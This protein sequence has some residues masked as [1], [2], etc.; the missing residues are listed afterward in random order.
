[1]S[2]IVEKTCSGPCRLTKLVSDFYVDQINKDQ[3]IRYRNKC[4][5][6]ISKDKA[7]HYRKHKEEICKRSSDYRKANPD[8]AVSWRKNNPNYNS[9]YNANNI[10]VTQAYKKTNKAK[11]KVQRAE[12]YKR[13]RKTIIERSIKYSLDNPGKTR[14]TKAKRHAA[15]LQRTVAWAN[16]EAI[17]DI[18]KD[19]E[20]I[21]LA[22]KTAGC[23]EIFTV[24]HIIPLQGKLVSGLHVEYNLDIITL[25]NNC[26]KSNS[27]IPS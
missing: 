16:L 26:S 18:Y 1:M 15:K 21:N 25:S 14:A 20:E 19:C 17:K 5:S 3:S 8:Y 23:T 9:K 22:A 2:N 13:N 4:K 11:I 7:K 6:C 24:D 27:F 12:H 10:E